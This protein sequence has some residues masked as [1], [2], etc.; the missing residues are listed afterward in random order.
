MFSRH[1]SLALYRLMYNTAGIASLFLPR[2]REKL[3]LAIKALEL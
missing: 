1:D 3:E 2:K